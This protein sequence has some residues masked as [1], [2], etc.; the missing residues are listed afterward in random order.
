[1]MFLKSTVGSTIMFKVEYNYKL[2]FNV[3]RINWNDGQGLLR[4]QGRDHAVAQ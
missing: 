4:G 3:R 1:L 2:K